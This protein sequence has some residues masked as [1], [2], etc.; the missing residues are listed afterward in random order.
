MV[1]ETLRAQAEI[2]D[3]WR[4]DALQKVV[5]LIDSEIAHSPSVN[6]LQ[7]LAII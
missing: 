5:G 2:D 6:A 7:K 1:V 4:E 3:P